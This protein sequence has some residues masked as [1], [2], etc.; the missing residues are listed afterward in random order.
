MDLLSDGIFDANRVVVGIILGAVI[1][2][3]LATLAHRLWHGR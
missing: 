3:T 1:V 2:A